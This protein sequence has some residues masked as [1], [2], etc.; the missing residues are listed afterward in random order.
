MTTKTTSL[1]VKEISSLTIQ[2]MVSVT[3]HALKADAPKAVATVNARRRLERSAD[4]RDDGG[5]GGGE[6]HHLSRSEVLSV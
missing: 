3:L 5:I 1:S 4:F 6:P 2:S